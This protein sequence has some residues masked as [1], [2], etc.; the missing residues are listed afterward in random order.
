MRTQHNL[1]IGCAAFGLTFPAQ[2]PAVSEQ[3]A[4]QSRPRRNSYLGACAFRS[5][6]PPRVHTLSA[7]YYFAPDSE[8]LY[9]NT[10][11]DAGF[12]FPDRDPLRLSAAITAAID[13]LKDQ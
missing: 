6:K 10:F 13:Q 8:G 12:R 11:K 9:L 2:N 1:Q 5:D 3:R 4:G 7:S